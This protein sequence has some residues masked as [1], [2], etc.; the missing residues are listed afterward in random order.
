MIPA[1]RCNSCGTFKQL[2]EFSRKKD[3]RDGRAARCKECAAD[4]QAL[5]RQT[6]EG[7]A[8]DQRYLSRHLDEKLAQLQQWRQAHPERI[9][10]I[11]QVHCKSKTLR[12]KLMCARRHARSCFRRASTLEDQARWQSRVQELNQKINMLEKVSDAQVH[13]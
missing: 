11:K 3:G 12:E 13:G 6:P 10:E 5:Y 7:I 1:R 2:E 4:K 9:K 8:T